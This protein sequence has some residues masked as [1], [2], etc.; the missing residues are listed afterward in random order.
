MPEL[1]EVETVMRGLSPI[2]VGRSIAGVELRRAGLRFPFPTGFAARLKG[3]RIVRLQR[4]AKY[5]P[6]NWHDAIDALSG[7]LY[8]FDVADVA[9]VNRNLR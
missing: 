6:G 7:T 5:I 8:R 3:R 2:L 4:R 1:P 9:V